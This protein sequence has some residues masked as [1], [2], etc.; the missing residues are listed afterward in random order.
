MNTVREAWMPAGAAPA[1]ATCQARM[2]DAGILVEI[3][4][5]AAVIPA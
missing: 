3:I 4:V 2:A 1:R 5:T